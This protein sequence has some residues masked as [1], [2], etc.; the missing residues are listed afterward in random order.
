MECT[1]L[2]GCEK[3]KEKIFLLILRQGRHG[4]CLQSSTGGQ[5]QEDLE[6]QDATQIHGKARDR[7]SMFEEVESEGSMTVE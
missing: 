7:G 3:S 1:F 4:V 5:R 6:F 2:N